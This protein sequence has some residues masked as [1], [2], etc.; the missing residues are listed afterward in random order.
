MPSSIATTVLS[1]LLVGSFAT[2]TPN[3]EARS[4]G[5][6][7]LT[8]RQTSPLVATS[9][10]APLMRVLAANG[11]MAR[12]AARVKGYGRGRLRDIEVEEEWAVSAT[13]GGEDVLLIL[14]TGSSDTWVAQKG[15]QCVNATLYPEKEKTCLFGPLYNGT[16]TEGMIKDVS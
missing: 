10:H 3:N 4:V 14:D 7:S 15:F 2:P 8:S 1:L 11:G 6:E 13:F 5:R 16:F 12:S 9:N